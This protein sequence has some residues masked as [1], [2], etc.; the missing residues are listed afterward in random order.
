LALKSA[1]SILQL[2]ARNAENDIRNLARMKERALQ[3]PEG[4][5]NAIA[6]GNVKTKSDSLFNPSFSTDNDDDEDED[7]EDAEE[8]EGKEKEWGSLP[9]PQNIVRCPPINWHKYAVVGESLDKLHED[10]KARPSEGMPQILMPDGTLRSGGEGYRRP[11][12]IGVAAPYAPGRDKIE[13]M[14][15]RKGGKR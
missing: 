13:K 2:Q 12:D 11:A 7:M 3:D 5:A 6:S 9:K 4:F 15:T 8:K 10:Q 14:S 1:M